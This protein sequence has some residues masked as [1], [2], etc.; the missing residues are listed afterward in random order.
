M[1]FGNYEPVHHGINSSLPSFL[2]PSEFVAENLGESAHTRRPHG[3][4]TKTTAPARCPSLPVHV[5][6]K[7]VSDGIRFFCPARGEHTLRAS[8]KFFFAPCR[9][10][11]F[12]PR[13]ENPSSCACVQ[14]RKPSKLDTDA[15]AVDGTRAPPPRRSPPITNTPI[16][17]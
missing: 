16:P 13:R 4:G 2:P 15:F 1:Q 6:H 9:F 7:T 10:P 14:I 8:N 11:E 3:F 17:K 12:P 5:L